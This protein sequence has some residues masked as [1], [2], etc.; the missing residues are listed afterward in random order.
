MATRVYGTWSSDF[1][2][3]RMAEH[4][5]WQHEAEYALIEEILDEVQSL[6]PRRPKSGRLFLEL[7]EHLAQSTRKSGTA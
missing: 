4:R 5:R 3:R 6:P 2:E 1:L 7:P